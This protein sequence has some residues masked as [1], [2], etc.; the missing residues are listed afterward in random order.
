MLY[1]L[2]Y[3]LRDYISAFNVFRYITFRSA[4]AAITALL[5]S[6]LLARLEPIA[7]VIVNKR[8][9]YPALNALIRDIVTVQVV[10]RHVVLK[11][12]ARGSVTLPWSA[13]P[14]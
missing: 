9:P 3:P 7:K 1:Y 5:I 8:R 10:P 14:R 6:F 12:P 4:Y 13:H 11:A 2:L